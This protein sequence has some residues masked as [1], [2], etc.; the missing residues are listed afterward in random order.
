MR[1]ALLADTYPRT[2]R[3]ALFRGRGE[4]LVGDMVNSAVGEEVLGYGP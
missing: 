4:H 1:I 2:N 3:S